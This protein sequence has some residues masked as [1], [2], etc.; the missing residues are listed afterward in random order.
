MNRFSPIASPT[1]DRVGEAC[2]EMIKNYKE[3]LMNPV[4]YT[5]RDVLNTPQTLF[6]AKMGFKQTIILSALMLILSV[7][8]YGQQHNTMN[9]LPSSY[10]IYASG[11]APGWSIAITDSLAIV[12]FE[13]DTAARTYKVVEKIKS[14]PGSD[15]SVYILSN[16]P[17]DKITLSITATINSGCVLYTAGKKLNYDYQARVTVESEKLNTVMTGCANVNNDRE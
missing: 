9:D 2:P 14:N 7:P 10:E 4:H 16:G 11:T 8:G 6:I 1:C 5:Y 3:F 12:Y 15:S 17:K 13:T